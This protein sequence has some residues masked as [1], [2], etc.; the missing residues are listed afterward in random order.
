MKA[1]LENR[2]LDGKP[3]VALCYPK[4]RIREVCRLS[5]VPPVELATPVMQLH[6]VEIADS[7]LIKE[8][9]GSRFEFQPATLGTNEPC[10]RD[11]RFV[12]LAAVVEVAH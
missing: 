4:K 2:E 7:D 8:R 9:A 12:S 1:A 5:A 11:D 10:Q 3:R 6:G